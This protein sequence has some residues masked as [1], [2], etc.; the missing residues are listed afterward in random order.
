M[1]YDPTIPNQNNIVR[2]ASGDLAKMQ[3]NFSVL[4][5]LASGTVISGTAPSA[6]IRGFYLG[7]PSNR[8]RY[9]VQSDGSDVF[10]VE[11]NTNTEASPSWE[12]VLSITQATGASPAFAYT[13]EGVT[14]T[15]SGHLATKGYVDGLTA[16]LSGLTD[17]A[18][19]AAT[20]GQALVFNGT[21]WVNS[22]L[23]YTVNDLT[24]VAAPS[25]AS[26]ESLVWN[27][28]QWIASGITGGSGTLSGLTDVNLTAV[29]DG[30]S[31]V[32]DQATQKWIDG[33][34][35]ASSLTD[36]TDTTITSPASGQHLVYN[37]S[38]WVNEDQASGV[39]VA[40]VLSGVQTQT[41]PQAAVTTM[42]GNEVPFNVGG[43]TVNS[44]TITVPGGVTRVDIIGQATWASSAVGTNYELE[45][46]V[47]GSAVSG[48]T[49]YIMAGKD[50]RRKSTTSDISAQ[51][52][53]AFDVPVAS[54]D[55]IT[56]KAYQDGVGAGLN[57]VGGTGLVVREAGGGGAGGG[58][59]GGSST[60]SGLTDTNLTS[61]A[62]EAALKFD[63]AT[64]KWID[65]TP[66]ASGVGLVESFDI[67]VDAV[68]SGDAFTIC[69]Y[70]F[71]PFDVETV[72]GK[73]T[74]GSCDLT[75]KIEDTAITGLSGITINTTESGN[76][77]SAAK[78]VA[79]G[80]TFK[81][82]V[83]DATTCSGLLLSV[84]TVRT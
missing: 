12:T 58:G 43:W 66:A 65:T 10:K 78:S 30:A 42:S 31:L 8:K 1:A 77:A 7:D 40:A 39:R 24:D 56:M 41:I 82:D 44:G 73:T 50:R 52:A 17:T 72:R 28:S 69:L 49:G 75:F 54:G 48:L 29:A 64:Q 71:Y 57:L 84:K 22:G 47:N 19:S 51:Q 33:T 63:Q 15:A 36:L 34:P 6:A 45:L 11:R 27:G 25:P 83:D 2:T 67:A 35:P 62:D 37:G 81:V 74:N 21:S 46:Y 80:N 14:P 9:F 76:D 13:V 79:L 61:V 5:P 53:V 60:L 59:G 16:S 38:A 4:A 23:A 20:S 55:T 70:A 26:G 32:F 3:E 68:A 18:I